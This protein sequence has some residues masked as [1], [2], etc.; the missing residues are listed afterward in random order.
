MDRV[1][2]STNDRRRRILLVGYRRDA[3]DAAFGLGFEASVVAERLPSRRRRERCAAT[4]RADLEVESDWA[5]V[6]ERLDPGGEL[7]GVLALT[8]RAVE[9]AARIRHALGLPGVGPETATA[10][11]DKLVMK[12]RVR[13]A[14]LPCADFLGDDEGPWSGAELVERLGLPLVL[15]ARRGSGSRHVHIIRRRRD[16][17]ERLADGWMAE[18]LVR[19]VEM[20][21]ETLW[22]DGEALFSN[23]TEY[24]EPRWV[25][26]MPAQLRPAARAGVDQL[27]AAALKALGVTR[28]ITHLELFLT[29]RGPV[30]G[31]VAV[32]PPGGHLMELLELVYGFDPWQA[33]LRLEVG[34][35]PEIPATPRAWGAV[36]VLHPGAGTVRRVSGLEAARRRPGVVRAQ[37]R[38][39]PGQRVPEREGLGQEVGHLAVLGASRQETL[40]RLAAASAEIHVDLDRADGPSAPPSSGF[41]DASP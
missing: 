4:L 31:E 6:A 29:A 35:V 5:R 24:T 15:K 1:L 34:E 26:L 40:E 9:P 39:R 13:A 38:L 25:N 16:L 27:N 7:E 8:E 18:R 14:G 3:L 19:G 10:C 30:F 17:P 28:G 12:R 20:S 41:D 11:S 21:V 33:V 23:P 22:A 32:R 36:R 2:G 37:L